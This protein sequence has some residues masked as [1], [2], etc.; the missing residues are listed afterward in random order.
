MYNQNAVAISSGFVIFVITAVEERRLGYFITRL[1]NDYS[2][3]TKQ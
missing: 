1:T 3:T 2:L